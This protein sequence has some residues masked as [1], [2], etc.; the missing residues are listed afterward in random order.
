MAYYCHWA[1][2]VKNIKV[3]LLPNLIGYWCYI[4]V[5]THMLFKSVLSHPIH[6]WTHHLQARY[7]IL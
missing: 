5:P 7:K 2:L 1:T 6:T 4:R 3:D